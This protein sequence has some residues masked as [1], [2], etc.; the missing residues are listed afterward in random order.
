VVIG[1]RPDQ[2]EP[3]ILIADEPTG[4]IWDPGS[5]GGIPQTFSSKSTTSRAPPWL[6]GHTL[7][8]ELIK[9]FPGPGY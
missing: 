2:N 9:R 7:A 3:V 8:T 1:P 4:K 5:V 6:N